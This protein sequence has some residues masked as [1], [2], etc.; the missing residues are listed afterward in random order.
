MRDAPAGQLVQLLD[1]GSPSNTRF[2]PPA[3]GHPGADVLAET[4]LDQLAEGG[5]V[6]H[7]RDRRDQQMYSF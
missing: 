6:G 1:Q 7:D 3:L 2:L 5:P 4:R